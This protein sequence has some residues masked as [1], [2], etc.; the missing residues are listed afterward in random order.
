MRARAHASVINNRAVSRGRNP[1]A[2]E[3]WARYPAGI[4]KMAG[5]M[6][7]FG[8]AGEKS[9][10]FVCRHDDDAGCVFVSVVVYGSRGR[11]LWG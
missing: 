10:I 11:D 4:R 1:F 9:Q 6:R 2:P 5:Y 7:L 3:G 8:R